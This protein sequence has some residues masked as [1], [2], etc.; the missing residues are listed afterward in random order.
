MNAIVAKVLFFP[1]YVSGIFNDETSRVD[2]ETL[3]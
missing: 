3:D 2:I 1:D